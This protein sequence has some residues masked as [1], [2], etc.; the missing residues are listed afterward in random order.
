MGLH[1]ATADVQISPVDGSDRPPPAIHASKHS[2]RERPESRSSSHCSR[3]HARRAIS[4]AARQESATPANMKSC[5]NGR[6][7]TNRRVAIDPEPPLASH[8]SGPSRA[9][10]TWR[11]NLHHA[12]SSL[13]PWRM[14]NRSSC[15]SSWLSR[16]SR[17]RRF[18]PTRSPTAIEDPVVIEKILAHLDA[19][20]PAV[21]AS[22]PRRAGHP[23][24]EGGAAAPGVSPPEQRTSLGG[25]PEGGGRPSAA[26]PQPN[27]TIILP[28]LA[29]CAA[30]SGS[31]PASRMRRIT[32]LASA[33][34]WG[35]A[36]RRAGCGAR[37]LTIRPHWRTATSAHAGRKVGSTPPGRLGVRWWPREYGLCSSS[38]LGARRRSA[39]GRREAEEDHDPVSPGVDEG[40]DIEVRLPVVERPDV[41]RSVDHR[42]GLTH[43]RDEAWRRVLPI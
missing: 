19:K 34:A 20:A 31:S 13:I 29:R 36:A 17:W 43:H 42:S 33:A 38:T 12:A 27:R 37:N 6:G 22:G 26:L 9:A 21:Q 5:S 35:G 14:P 7:Q 25:P 3:S 39:G 2:L 41:T 8:E 4:K 10:V 18:W 23:H 1:L 32:A 15:S 24:R 11:R 40:V 28:I 16:T 30:M